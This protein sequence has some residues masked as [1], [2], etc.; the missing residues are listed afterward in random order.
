MVIKNKVK[1]AVA[2]LKGE[3]I[4]TYDIEKGTFTGDTRALERLKPFGDELHK[5][6]IQNEAKGTLKAFGWFTDNLW[7]NEDVRAFDKGK[8]LTDEECQDILDEVLT[9]ECLT[10]LVNDL[11]YTRLNNGN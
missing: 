7:N 10:E 3:V 4:A 11:I 5:E 1:E 2:I 6:Y 9:S 8:H